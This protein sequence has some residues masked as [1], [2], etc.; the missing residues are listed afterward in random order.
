MLAVLLGYAIMAIFLDFKS[1]ELSVEQDGASLGIEMSSTYYY[2][3]MF[4][5][6][7]TYYYQTATMIFRR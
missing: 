5:E 1:R 2:H 6:N 7:S 4:I 3:I